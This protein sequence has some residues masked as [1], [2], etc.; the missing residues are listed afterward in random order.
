M[1]TYGIEISDVGFQFLE[2]RAK[3]PMYLIALLLGCLFCSTCVE[4]KAHAVI[5]AKK[6]IDD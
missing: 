6:I 5:Y 4:D 1:Q 2:V 3:K